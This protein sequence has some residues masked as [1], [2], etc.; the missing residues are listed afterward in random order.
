M[1]HLLGECIKVTV[2]LVCLIYCSSFFFF[3]VIDLYSFFLYIKKANR[4]MN[5]V[6]NIIFGLVTCLFPP[7]FF[8]QLYQLG[9][10]FF[11][12][13]KIFVCLLCT[14]NVNLYCIHTKSNKYYI[15]LISSWTMLWTFFWFSELPLS[16]FFFFF[17]NFFKFTN[18]VWACFFF[19]LL[20][21]LYMVTFYL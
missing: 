5:S 16:L 10:S 18:L 15:H 20:K 19:F 8:L 17:F 1:W 14:C 4:L 11:F 9:L 7:F 13:L 3:L 2:L 6:M 12:F 21:D